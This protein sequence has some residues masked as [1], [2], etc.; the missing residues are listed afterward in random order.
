MYVPPE[1]DEYETEE[2]DDDDDDAATRA[3]EPG[4]EPP[5]ELAGVPAPTAAV[6][7]PRTG[8]GA[9]PTTK[10]PLRETSGNVLRPMPRSPKP[11]RQRTSIEKPLAGTT[12][13]GVENGAENI[14][15]AWEL[16]RADAGGR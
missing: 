12:F 6:P 9:A 10:A 5:V 15:Y 1:S 4:Q 13:S 8:L 3:S 14:D 16:M 7:A 2:Y 11:L